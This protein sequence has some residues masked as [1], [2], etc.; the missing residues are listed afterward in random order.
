MCFIPFVNRREQSRRRAQCIG[1]EYPSARQFIFLKLTYLSPLCISVLSVFPIKSQT[2]FRKR[3]DGKRMGGPAFFTDFLVS[4]M[5][6]WPHRI[7]RRW[8]HSWLDRSTS[9]LCCTVSLHFTENRFLNHFSE[10]VVVDVGRVKR[11]TFLIINEQT[12]DGHRPKRVE[13]QAKAE[14]AERQNKQCKHE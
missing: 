9:Q 8:R 12:A 3:S 14:Q 10:G 5:Y 11:S 7:L 13:E 4:S 2:S 1:M 6:S